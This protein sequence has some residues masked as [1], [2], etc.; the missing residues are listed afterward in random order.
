MPDGSIPHAEFID[1]VWKLKDMQAEI[2]GELFAT[3]AWGL[4]NKRNAF[5]HEGRCKP[6][7]NIA[8][9]SAKYVEEF[10]QSAMKTPKCPL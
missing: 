5:K 1:V 7:K 9:D 2:D 4:W 8:K 3:I 10:R 6:A